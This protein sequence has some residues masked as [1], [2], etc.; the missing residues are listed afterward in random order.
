MPT[1][2]QFAESQMESTGIS[3]KIAANKPQNAVLR[4]PC[5]IGGGK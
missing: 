2:V 3:A 4:K 5:F 1:P